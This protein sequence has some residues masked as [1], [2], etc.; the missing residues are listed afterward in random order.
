MP[1]FKSQAFNFIIRNRHLLRGK[2]HKEI[3]ESED[4]IFPFREMCEKGTVRPSSLPAGVT[5]NE[6]KI[7]NIR[8]EWIIP[9]GANP[10]KVIMYVHGG[11]YISGSCNDHRAFVA[12]FAEYCGYICLVYEYGIAPENPYPA[13]VDD[14]VKVYRWLL[15]NGYKPQNILIAGESAGGGLCLALLLK[16]K[17]LQIVQPEAAVVISPWTDLTCSSESYKTKNK[18]SVAPLNSWHIFGK[19]YYGNND[20][21]NP[22]ISPLFGD[23]AGLPPIFINAGTDD[24]LYE[25]GERFYRKAKKAG[26]DATFKAGLRMIHCYPFFAPFFKEATEAMIEI[27]EFVKK[28]L[29]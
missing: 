9:S 17:D 12:K 23:L 24:E 28:Q 22:F 21:K 13:A 7:E 16:L 6:D 4:A 14:S 2:F 29:K 15:A 5:I 20:P 10:E 11:G 1:S 25:D 3:F 27:S 19:A 18:V 8:A 26:V